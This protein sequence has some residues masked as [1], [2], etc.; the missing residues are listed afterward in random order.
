MQ[1]Q[2]NCPTAD[3]NIFPVEKELSQLQDFFKAFSDSTRLKI[4]FALKKGESCVCHLAQKVGLTQTNCSHQLAKL[5]SLSLVKKRKEGKL[6][7][8]ALDDDHVSQ[9]L[10]K[11]LEHI[12]EDKN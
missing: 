6:I 2:H 7:Y 12:Q 4:L 1:A 11:G 10:L 8:Y 9:I 3:A 5:N